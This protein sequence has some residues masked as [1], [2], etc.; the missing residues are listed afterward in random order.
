MHKQPL[1]KPGKSDEAAPATA[2]GRF[3]RAWIVA[4]MLA[5]FGLCSWLGSMQSVWFDE[6]YSIMLAKQSYG[7]L[8]DLTA[9]DVHPPL[10]Y[11]LLKVWAGVVGMGEFAL[12]SLSAVFAA[13]AAGVGLLFARRAFGLR[14]MVVATPFL[15][16]APYLL[17]YGY[18][19]RMYALASLIG[20]AATY[21]LLRAVQARA[22]RP[23]LL[24]WGSY[25]VLV[26]LGMYTLYY[27]ALIWFAHALWVF[28][29]TRR[30]ESGRRLLARWGAAIAGSIVLF[31]P[32]IGTL[33]DQVQ[34]TARTDITH[35]LDWDGFV[36]IF[37]YLFA[38]QDKW[39]LSGWELAAIIGAIAATAYVIVQAFR[40]AGDVR[41]QLLLLALYALVPFAVLGLASLP[42][43][44]PLFFMRYTAHFVIG[45]YLLIGVSLAIIWRAR[46]RGA[47]VLLAAYIVLLAYGVS[48]LH[49]AGNFIFEQLKRPHMEQVAAD[50][51]PCEPGSVVLADDAYLYFELAYYVPNCDLRFFRESLTG[52]RGGY[53][54]LHNS[55]DQYFGG[56][57]DASTIYAVQTAENPIPLPPDYRLVSTTEFPHLELAVYKRG[58]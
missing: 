10:Y 13:L 58:E 21:V 23:A 51:T 55:P 30:R 29:M 38:F 47:L 27:M 36:G 33:F 35:R 54:I 52:E 14:A 25:A 53:A 39:Q 5:V 15:V 12:R 48:V 44:E 17:R 2:G 16:L 4:V 6:A 41:P 1:N 11:L 49:S 50:I 57:I 34:N 19:I 31:L 18:E 20:I 32:W 43:F 9:V 24:W 26:A 42:P 28:Y 56:D 3:W 45:A 40:V 8:I 37:S 7:Q 22:G 46:V